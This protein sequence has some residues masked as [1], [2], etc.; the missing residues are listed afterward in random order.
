[1]IP[2]PDHSAYLP[3]S[4]IYQA[5]RTNS[6]FA[7]N[8]RST[9]NYAFHTFAQQRY[10]LILSHTNIMAQHTE[11]FKAFVKLGAFFREYREPLPESQE[12]GNS[13]GSWQEKLHDV[14][15]LAGL[16]NGWFT[17]EN[18][19]HALAA[20]GD[21]LR[22][23]KL[24]QW[25]SAYS[26]DRNQ[27][28]N[29]AVIMAG[30]IPLVGFH[31]FLSVLI[32]G[33][34][35]LV[36]PASND[37]TL[38][39]FIAKYLHYLEPGFKDAVK[40]AEGPLKEYDAVIATGSDNTARYFNYYFGNK[41]H[42]IRK[43]RNSAAVLEGNETSSELLALGWD[44]FAYFGLGCR[45]VSK[46]YVPENYD[47]SA[48]FD[49]I[50]SFSEILGHRKYGNNYDYNKAV[51]LMSGFPILD[52]GFLILKEDPSYCSPIGTL[53][54]EYYN[55]PEKLQKKLSGER[56]IIQCVVG[57][58]QMG[59]EIPF[60]ETQNPALWDYADGVDTVDFLLKT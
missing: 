36:K 54:F 23:E 45:N 10:G 13:L 51:F 33:N 3:A 34:N 2:I 38:L 32:T 47:F 48:F 27:V 19:G 46:L 26:A 29:V 1:V 41:P 39:P 40:F 17:R 28:K 31:D 6:I 44:I 30:N 43:N 4:L 49:A 20:W 18:V 55:D 58:K 53:Y 7:G 11:R 16:K 37:H 22:E 14:V 50:K 21:V 12:K 15:V 52:N 35:I 56:E 9:S 59:N 24:S 57:H 8:K 5:Y 60:G 42:I 25:L